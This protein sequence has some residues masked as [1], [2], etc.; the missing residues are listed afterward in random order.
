MDTP[1]AIYTEGVLKFTITK[2]A[3]TVSNLKEIEWNLFCSSINQQNIKQEFQVTTLYRLFKMGLTEP[4][5]HTWL[6]GY[7]SWVLDLKN[8]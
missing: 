3:A 8:I 1:I 6:I 4:I 2:I 5:K 7:S